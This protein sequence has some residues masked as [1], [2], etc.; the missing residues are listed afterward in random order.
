MLTIVPS[1]ATF[2]RA[3]CRSVLLQ[4]AAVIVCALVPHGACK[5]NKIAASPNT[6][7]D[8]ILMEAIDPMRGTV[9]P[10]QPFSS[11]GQLTISVRPVGAAG[12]VPVA[13]GA[14]GKIWLVQSSIM[15]S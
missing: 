8:L 5:Q 13:T 12:R 7:V 9:T 3:F 1:D 2:R 14:L 6:L 10:P 4:L 15:S 11:A